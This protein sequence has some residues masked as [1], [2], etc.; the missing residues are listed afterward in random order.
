VTVTD[1]LQIVEELKKSLVSRATGGELGDLEYSKIRAV[2]LSDAELKPL[3]PAFL[4]KCR[5]E[6]EFWGHMKHVSGTYQGR[7][8]YLREQF[9]GV[10]TFLELGGGTPVAVLGTTLFSQDGLKESWQKALS[11]L[12]TDPD[13]AVT[14]ARSMVETVCKHILDDLHQSYTGKEEMP[15]LYQMVAKC[16]ELSPDRDVEVVLKQIL[17][18]CSSIAA[19]LAGLRNRVGDSHGQG[20]RRHKALPRHAEL[21]VNA[22]GTLSIFLYRSHK[23]KS[24][25]VQTIKK[26]AISGGSR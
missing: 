22:A 18:G 3:L 2:L 14:S 6:G 19:G 17:Q 24:L 21:A 20:A 11:R 7:R 15:Q 25:E 4:S 26:G 9:D 16:L 12:G 5:N 1:R 8:D 13:G 23:E 10:L